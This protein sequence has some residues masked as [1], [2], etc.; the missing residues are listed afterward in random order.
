MLSRL[1]VEVTR[2]K[3]PEFPPTHRNYDTFFKNL[4]GSI[5]QAHF[6]YQLLSSQKCLFWVIE[7]EM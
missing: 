7:K 4:M 1:K 2:G 5:V 3:M 6:G